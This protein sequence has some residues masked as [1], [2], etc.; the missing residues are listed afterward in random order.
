MSLENAINDVHALT[1]SAIKL[2]TIQE[3]D[4]IIG[5]LQRELSNP[6]IGPRELVAL[7]MDGV[8]NE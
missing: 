6:L 2:G 4:R 5:I 7:I 1:A 8:T 3:R